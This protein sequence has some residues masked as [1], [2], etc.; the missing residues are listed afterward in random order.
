MS[1]Y[2][3]VLMMSVQY[4]PDISSLG[5][6]LVLEHGDALGQIIP[7]KRQEAEMVLV[8]NEELDN[9]YKERK[10]I[11]GAGGFRLN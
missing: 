4:L 9:L 6:D 11:R 7:V 3:G 5:N 1:G 2:E 10:G 8:S